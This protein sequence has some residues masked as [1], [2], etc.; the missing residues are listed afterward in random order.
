MASV[1]RYW[2]KHS[3]KVAP[4]GAAFTGPTFRLVMFDVGPG[5]AILLV[6]GKEAALVDGGAGDQ[7]KNTELAK[8][9]FR[10]IKTN[11]LSLK[12][13]IPSHPHQ[14]HLNAIPDL[15]RLLKTAGKLTRGA[16]FY[17]NGEQ[18]SLFAQNLL[19]LVKSLGLRPVVPSKTL[20]KGLGPSAIVELFMNG[21]TAHGVAYKSVWARV[22]YGDAYFLLTG[23]VYMDYEKKLVKDKGTALRAQVLKVTHHGS[24]GGT[25]RDFLNV[26][27]PLIA[28]ASTY[29][30]PSGRPDPKH[31]IDLPTAGR[32]AQSHVT[33]FETAAHGNI[34]LETDGVTQS[35]GVLLSVTTTK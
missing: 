12:F 25:S 10:W 26:V 32:L 16:P 30:L 7:P 27:R 4:A 5:E 9:L 11:S 18:P 23:D 6:E 19:T 22:K 14:D 35:N 3:L 31:N 28:I 20:R 15:L 33:V 17:H 13:F 1:L 24:S 21:S 2:L 29:E 34:T 8:T